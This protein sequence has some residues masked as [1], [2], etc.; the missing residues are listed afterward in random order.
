MTLVF[1]KAIVEKFYHYMLKVGY[2]IH[3]RNPCYIPWNALNIPIAMNIL[4][5]LTIYHL[6]K[7]WRC[8][9]HDQSS[10]PARLK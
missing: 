4:N 5:A 8:E 2:V 9:K 6:W 3:F 1:I 7:P 10:E